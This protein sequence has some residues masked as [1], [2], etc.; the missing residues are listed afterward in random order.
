MCSLLTS[1]AH[2]NWKY[3]SHNVLSWAWKCN[4]TPGTD[5]TALDGMVQLSQSFKETLRNYLL[6]DVHYWAGRSL[7]FLHASHDASFTFQALLQK[8]CH[9][10]QLLIMEEALQSSVHSNRAMNHNCLSYLACLQPANLT[11]I[12]APTDIFALTQHQSWVL[13]SYRSSQ[14]VDARQ[15]S[16]SRCMLYLSTKSHRSGDPKLIHQ[17][18]VSIQ[19]PDHALQAFWCAQMP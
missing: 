14:V 4:L 2:A 10:V 11:C 12:A 6:A 15:L 3:Q 16:M 17:I 18:H 5:S 1:C 13:L 9:H 19:V 7:V 8:L